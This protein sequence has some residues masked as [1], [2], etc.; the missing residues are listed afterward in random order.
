[1]RPR[2]LGLLQSCCA[3]ELIELLA[4]SAARAAVCCPP[5]CCLLTSALLCR[6]L[7]HVTIA[8]GGVLPNVSPFIVVAAAAAAS[9]PA[10]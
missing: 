2:G 9:R 10:F 6:L 5:R 7:G 3:L 8:S 1:M 4:A